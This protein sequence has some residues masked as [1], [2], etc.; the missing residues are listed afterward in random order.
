MYLT[1]RQK[2]IIDL[3]KRG[4]TNQQIAQRLGIS[5]QTVKNALQ[6][7]YP[8]I[9]AVDRA[10]AVYVCLREGLIAFD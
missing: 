5:E 1:G 2:D 6:R 7:L 9:G 10:N 3:I 8:Y 4:A